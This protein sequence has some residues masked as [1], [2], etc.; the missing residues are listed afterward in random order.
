MVGGELSV[1]EHGVG[2]GRIGCSPHGA[3]GIGQRLGCV[4]GAD[5]QRGVID[6]DGGIVRLEAE[7]ALEILPR[8]SDVAVF[9]FKFS[10]DEV[11]RRAQLGIALA[12]QAGE[13]VGIDLAFL[14]DLADE[15]AL[16][17]KAVGG[18]KGREI[19]D[20]GGCRCDMSGHAA[21]IDVIYGRL[22][23]RV[24][25]VA[26]VVFV[27]IAVFADV[28]GDDGAA[29]FQMDGVGPCA[30]GESHTRRDAL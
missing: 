19:A 26:D 17:G 21:G 25:I 1:A 3:L 30:Q 13:N 14:D 29:I 27:V 22:G 18:S 6:K 20:L 12:F 4:S 8:L 5:Q 15:I 23:D 2:V 24:G 16:V 28:I 9:E 7:G 11:G 10:G